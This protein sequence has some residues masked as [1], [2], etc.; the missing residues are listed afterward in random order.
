MPQL[1]R[2]PTD[3]DVSQSKTRGTAKSQAC[4]N[5][6]ITLILLPPF[7]PNSFVNRL[8]NSLFE[9]KTGDRIIRVLNTVLFIN[10]ACRKSFVLPSTVG[11]NDKKF[12]WLRSQ[13]SLSTRALP[14]PKAR[15]FILSQL[16]Y[17][18]FFY[19][20]V[21]FLF[22]LFL[23]QI[24][25]TDTCLNRTPASYLPFA[26]FQTAFFPV[27]GVAGN[28]RPSAIKNSLIASDQRSI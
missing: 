8:L 14:P 1:L 17:K 6:Y 22:L 25:N 26:Y 11:L 20:P 15:L 7:D 3:V 24:F 18:C 4:Y 23:T 27:F 12:S 10:K 5:V 16:V 13:T 19:C 28:K 2:I 21:A 9:G